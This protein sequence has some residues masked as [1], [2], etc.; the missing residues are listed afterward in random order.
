[1]SI[2]VFCLL[3][4]LVGTAVSQPSTPVN[5]TFCSFDVTKSV[6]GTKSTSSAIL[7]YSVYSIIHPH[8]SR[9]KVCDSI[10]QQSTFIFLTADYI[11]VTSHRLTISATGCSVI[12]SFTY[13]SK[14]FGH[15]NC[16][17]THLLALLFPQGRGCHR[18]RRLP[19]IW[20]ACKASLIIRHVIFT[21][22]YLLYTNNTHMHLFKI[23]VLSVLL[24]P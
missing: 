24:S 14:V 13:R 3:C 5:L 6:M 12:L 19:V 23:R 17:I 4:R 15:F 21:T 22:S 2:S 9:S 20:R 16:F 11:W 8:A 18:D 10:K 7:Y 1:M